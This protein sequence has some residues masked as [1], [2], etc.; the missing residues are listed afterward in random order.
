MIYYKVNRQVEGKL[1]AEKTKHKKVEELWL[2]FLQFL[3]EKEKWCKENWQSHYEEW[4]TWMRNWCETRNI[5][6]SRQKFGVVNCQTFKRI[7]KYTR[8]WHINCKKK[9]KYYMSTIRNIQTIIFKQSKPG[10][11]SNCTQSTGLGCRDV[12]SFTQ[13]P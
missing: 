8:H 11:K 3:K 5:P 1:W 9:K 10:C 6:I 2:A 4:K 13:F 12:H 7:R